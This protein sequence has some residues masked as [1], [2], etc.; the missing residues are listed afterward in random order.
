MNLTFLRKEYL[1]IIFLLVLFE[2]YNMNVY[3]SPFSPPNMGTLKTVEN[4]KKIGT[5]GPI[6]ALFSL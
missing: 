5:Y 3:F 1:K 2:K 4:G 6:L